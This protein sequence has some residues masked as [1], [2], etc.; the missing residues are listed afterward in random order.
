MNKQENLR[1][2]IE[3]V[4]IKNLG[5]G[6]IHVCPNHC[7]A[8]LSTTAHVVQTWKVDP[9]GTFIEEIST[10]MTV[11]GPDNENIW[12][13]TEC[14]AEAEMIECR[15][16]SIE[17]FGM[18]CLPVVPRGCAFWIP[19]GM[20]NAQYVPILPDKRDVPTITIEKHV[21]YLDDFN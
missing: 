13:C 12:E 7:E 18:L 6:H 15:E 17:N 1:G 10:D 16:F 20:T 5:H 8:P 11:H 14:G 21:F 2:K 4:E 3:G 19:R 9:F